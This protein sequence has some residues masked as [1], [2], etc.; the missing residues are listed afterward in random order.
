MLLLK[1][2]KVKYYRAEATIIDREDS[3]EA[4]A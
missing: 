3:T 1:N 4:N 2:G